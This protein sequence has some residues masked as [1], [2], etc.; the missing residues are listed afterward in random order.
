MVDQESVR[1]LAK[2]AAAKAKHTPAP[3]YEKVA[4]AITGDD[5]PAWLVK[6]LKMWGPCLGHC[7]MWTPPFGKGFYERLCKTVGCSHMSGLCARLLWPP[8]LMVSAD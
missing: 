6:F 7:H 3:G 5:P 1:P 4:R 8:A 2:S